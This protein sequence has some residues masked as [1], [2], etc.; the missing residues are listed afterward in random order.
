MDYGNNECTPR[1]TLKVIQDKFMVLP[2]QAILCSLAGNAVTYRT[3]KNCSCPM[4]SKQTEFTCP[5]I[6]LLDC[7][8]I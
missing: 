1:E 7:K 2:A 5:N 8:K 6:N 4:S 3:P